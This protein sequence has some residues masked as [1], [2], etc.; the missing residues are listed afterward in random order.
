MTHLFPEL[1]HMILIWT[2]NP[3]L[4]EAFLEPEKNEMNIF[5]IKQNS[6]K[7]VSKFFSCITQQGQIISGGVD[8]PHFGSLI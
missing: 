3:H 1:R 5:T 6:W 4:R 7:V 2:P 8:S